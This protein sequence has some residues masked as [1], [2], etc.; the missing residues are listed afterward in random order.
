MDH[1]TF[2]EE[3]VGPY[4]APY[5][6]KQFFISV[7][8]RGDLSFIRQIEERQFSSPLIDI[9][10]ELKLSASKYLNASKS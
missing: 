4:G 8:A 2:A 3:K 6:L 5:V 1:K 10:G 9:T 7:F